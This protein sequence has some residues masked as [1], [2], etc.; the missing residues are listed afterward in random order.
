M[1]Y[2]K[3]IVYEKLIEPLL[4]K[5]RGIISDFI[6]QNSTVVD[7]GCGTG[8]LAFR[9][10]QD[11]SC[12][13]HGVDL[14]SG[15]IARAK[16]RQANANFPKVQFTEAD[17]R[18]LDGILDEQ[19]DNATIS[20]FLHSIPP[21]VRLQVIQEAMRV[22]KRIVIADYVVTKQAKSFSGL[23]IKGIEK[24]AGGEHSQSF[25]EF[26]A[27]GGLEP[28]LREAGL[29]IVRERVHPSETV[30]VVVVERQKS[31]TN[32]FLSIFEKG[33]GEI[34]ST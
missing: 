10:A 16:Y 8:A 7:I 11:R 15:K 19:F 17:A 2:L 33:K 24:F 25:E 18:H 12:T 14:A 29:V 32:F 34:Y 30:R 20:L 27:S 31:A 21:N 28:L 6:E 5:V 3:A 22:A 4:D 13:V 9:L 1:E 23:A 26:R